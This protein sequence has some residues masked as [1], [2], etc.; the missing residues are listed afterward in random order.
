MIYNRKG[1]IVGDADEAMYGIIN[2]FYLAQFFFVIL[3]G[4]MAWPN[5]AD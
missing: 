4:L 1:Y 3:L 2:N 5:F